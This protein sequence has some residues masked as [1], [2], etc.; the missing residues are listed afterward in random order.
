LNANDEPKAIRV[1]ENFQL[2]AIFLL[3]LGG[4]A[5]KKLDTKPQEGAA[6]NVYET[7]KRPK[8]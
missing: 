3:F 6:I 5:D 1:A 2:S 4:G 7:S 8:C